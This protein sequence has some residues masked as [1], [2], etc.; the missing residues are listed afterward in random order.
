MSGS[1]SSH[2]PRRLV[3]VVDFQQDGSCLAE[4][5]DGAVS[6]RK[7]VGIRPQNA[8]QVVRGLQT[9]W[10]VAHHHESASGDYGSSRK[11]ITDGARQLIAA[12]ILGF[13]ARVE[14][15]NVL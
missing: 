5:A 12:K 3:R 9:G 11:C 4:Q 2:W 7:T 6:I 15:F 13:T 1:V 14:Q 10:R 8:A